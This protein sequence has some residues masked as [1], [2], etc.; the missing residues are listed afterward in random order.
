MSSQTQI[1]RTPYHIVSNYL[2]DDEYINQKINNLNSIID[3]NTNRLQQK[4]SFVNNLYL[5][6]I[7][8]KSEIMKINI[9]INHTKIN[10]SLLEKEKNISPEDLDLFSIVD[11]SS[12]A[13]KI[14]NEFYKKYGLKPNF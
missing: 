9:F 13:L 4:L 12:E 14:I 8:N 6:I 2:L 1:I 5:N 11:S 7:E 3:I 10:I